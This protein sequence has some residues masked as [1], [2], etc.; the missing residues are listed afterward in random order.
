MQ[1]VT[2]DDKRRLRLEMA[3]IRDELSGRTALDDALFQRLSALELY[4]SARQLLLYMSFRSEA[5]TD[6]LLKRALCDGKAVYAPRCLPNTNEMR[7]YRILSADDLT[8]GSYGIPEPSRTAVPLGAPAPDAL[9]VVPGLAFT[10]HGEHLGYGRGYYDAF[11]TEK[12]LC[13]V[14]LCYD[15]QV[16]NDIPAAPHDRR[17]DYVLTPTRFFDCV[18]QRKGSIV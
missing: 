10:P 13:T 17:M 6:A 8:L 14:G 18:R 15:E 2:D 16:L 1:S 9:C 7:F 5:A 12:T 4:R 11:L 3:R